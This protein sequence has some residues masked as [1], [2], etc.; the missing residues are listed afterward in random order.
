VLTPQTATTEQ[1][2]DN[3]NKLAAPTHAQ[4]SYWWFVRVK[5]AWP[6]E[7]EPAWYMDAMLARQVFRP[8]LLKHALDIE[9][10]RFHRR[11]VRDAAG[12][13]FSFIFYA[14]KPVA[15]A[16][17]S[18]LA[19]NSLLQNLIAAGKVEALDLYD[20]NKKP[21]SAIEAT[22]DRNWSPAMQRAWP[23]YATGVSQLWL[24]L[25]DQF[26]A[27]APH[28]GENPPNEKN[29]D[30][31]VDYYRHIND[32]LVATWQNEGGHALLHHLNALFGYSEVFVYER[33]QTRF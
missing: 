6:E 8:E 33:R 26:V 5:M 27:S 14:K 17:L 11:A 13:R 28:S 16:I 23:Y 30:E 10:W 32:Q 24:S 25:I 3:E 12:H 18:D 20:A 15:Q 21:D 7:Q 9:M 29:I 19:A 22:S 4:L 1:I 2:S 31:L